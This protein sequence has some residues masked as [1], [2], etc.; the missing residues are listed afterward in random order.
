MRRHHGR[1]P[2]PARSGVGPAELADGGAPHHHVFQG[3]RHFL[4]PAQSAICAGVSPLGPSGTRSVRRA[5]FSASGS[6]APSM[7]AM[8][9]RDGNAGPGFLKAFHH[10][11]ETVEAAAGQRRRGGGAG[12]GLFRQLCHQRIGDG[13]G[14][15][16]R[17]GPFA[18]QRREQ[19]VQAAFPAMIHQFGA[20]A[21]I[22]AVLGAVA[23][24]RPQ[25]GI[26]EFDLS[27]RQRRGGQI[28]AEGGEEAFDI[29]FA[30]GHAWRDRR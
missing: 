3:Q 8:L 20:A 1:R 21:G 23:D 16:A 24:Q 7:C 27:A 22:V 5:P 15:I 19:P 18:A 12:R 13:F 30:H 2:F 17:G 9:R 6:R 14:Q 11:L 26:E 4:A 28:F 10:L 25:A 29:A